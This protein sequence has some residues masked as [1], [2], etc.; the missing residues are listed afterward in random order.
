MIPLEIPVNAG[1]VILFSSPLALSRWRILSK[2]DH[3][4]LKKFLGFNS[5][6]SR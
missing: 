2:G 6:I 4:C 5:R 1:E 3:V